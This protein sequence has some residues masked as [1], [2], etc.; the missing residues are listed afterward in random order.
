MGTIGGWMANFDIQTDLEIKRLVIV[1]R[2]KSVY[3][4]WRETS[5]IN[6]QNI[7]YIRIGDESY[8]LKEGKLVQRWDECIDAIDAEVLKVKRHKIIEG[9]LDGKD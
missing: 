3:H 2:G 9:V 4:Y 5:N 1:R 7:F 8:I 6:K